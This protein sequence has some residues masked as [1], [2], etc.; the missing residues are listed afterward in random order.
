MSSRHTART[1]LVTGGGS[2]IGAAIARA[3]SR[4]GAAVFVAARSQEACT[5]VVDEL[6][7]SGASAWPLYLD[8]SDRDSIAEALAATREHTAASI[9]WLV[10]NAGIAETAPF[11]A[12]DR[13]GVDA[14]AKHMD[15]NF[16][17]AR[18][19]IEALGPGMV[20]R[21]YGRIV[22]LASSAALQGYAYA[23][24][25][26]ASKHALLGY[27]RSAALELV[28]TDVTL[29]VVCPHYVDSPMTDG[30]VARIV[31]KTGK[32]A[33]E[34]RAFLSRQ[35]PG[36]TLI[37]VDEVADV[38]RELVLG[39]RNGALVELVGGRGIRAASE[40]VIWREGVESHGT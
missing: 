10:N 32:S 34:T 36:G 37:S 2:G 8:V 17:G 26:C 3:L 29:N 14:Y 4:A 11:L 35:N 33:D 1:A 6:R 20:E 12:R 18:R 19:L 23:S 38:V 27:S 31:K 22:N 30:T 24:A 28:R 13:S 40:T 7:A 9:D 39:T 5:K 16:H 15:V 21:G 25:Y